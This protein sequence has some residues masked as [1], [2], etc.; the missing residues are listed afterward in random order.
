MRR[1]RFERK[2]NWWE[3][4]NVVIFLYVY[5]IGGLAAVLASTGH[6]L[7]RIFG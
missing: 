2:R 5:R 7:A 1:H 6:F 3:S 4:D